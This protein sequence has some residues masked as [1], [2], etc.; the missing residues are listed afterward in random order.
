M[1]TLSG[2]VE[3]FLF[4]DDQQGF[5]VFV[6]KVSKEATV[7]VRAHAASFHPGQDVEV[8]GAWVTHPKFGKQFEAQVCKAILP[9]SALG[10]RRYLGSGMI[11]GIG[12]SYADKLVSYFGT[13]VLEVIDKTPERLSEV[14][15]IGPKRVETIAKA[16]QEQ[17]EIANIMV[18]LQEKG[19]SPAYASKIYKKYGAASIAVVTENPYR[20]AEEV[21]GVGFTLADQLAQNLGFE[22]ESV[23]RVKAGILFALTT[24]T[25]HGHLYAELED[26]KKISA[27]L[28]DLTEEHSVKDL[29]KKALHALYDEQKI[30]LISH[31]NLHYVTT[32]QLYYVE[33]GT[34]EKIKGLIAHAPSKSI[35]IDAVYQ[36]LRVP[37]AG[38]IELNEAQQKG[39]IDSLQ[40]KVS[41][42][43]GGPGTGK[44]TLTKKLLQFLEE[45]S[46]SYKIA[47]PTGRAAKRIMENSG[48]FAVTIHRLLEF[49]VQGGGFTHNEKNALKLDYLI[50]DEASMID[51]FLA[52]A[53]LKAVPLT[54]HVIFIGD[55]D[56][57]PPVGAGNF[58]LDLIA[59]KTVPVTQLSYIFR[60]A[61]N[62]LI[63]Y[64]AHRINKGEMPVSEAEA[65]K[66]DYYFISEQDP[67]QLPVHLKKIVHGYLP[68]VGIKPEQTIIL[69]PMNKGIAGT[70]KLN[71]DMQSLINPGKKQQVQRMFSTFTLQDPVI[72]LRNNYDKNVFNGDIG[73]IAA[74]NDEEKTVTVTFPEKE[75]EYDFTELDELMLAYAISI[76]KSQ[77]SEFDA[78]IIPLFMQH[79]TLL[80]RNLLYTALTR[81]K[82]LCIFIGQHKAIAIALKNNSGSARI[83][84]LQQYLTS[85]LQCR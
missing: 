12:K 36:T 65:T 72:Q 78:V 41:V 46:I 26:L 31:E 60:Q 14:P 54:A 64:N 19:A 34:A 23:K 5:G 63:T 22:K 32:S 43:T 67:T 55:T 2:T 68:R 8:E 16:W 10:L 80:Q 61:Q 69:S 11:K 59:S 71:T 25:T 70:Q 35:D 4:Q 28:L 49:N 30:K 51:A 44:T 18:F 85:D 15:G 17:K 24:A 56:Q 50:I 53:L 13:S 77:G 7:V 79:F 27:E 29:I 38:E 42:I 37:T 82:K 52:Y 45:R 84:F 20:L 62:S 74:I 57:L 58:L 6:L 9:T 47:A 1:E 40:A 75:V 76:H 81:A 66:K 21:W 3:R 33:K 48:K 83:T 39:I 73:T